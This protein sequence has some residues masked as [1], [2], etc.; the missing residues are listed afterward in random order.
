MDE[1]DMVVGRRS[2]NYN[3]LNELWCA[4]FGVRSFEVYCLLYK[5]LDGSD[6]HMMNFFVFKVLIKG[7]S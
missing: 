5:Q 4:S 2:G 6:C 3:V 1:C 7:N